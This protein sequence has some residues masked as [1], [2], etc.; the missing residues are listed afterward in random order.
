MKFGYI[1]LGKKGKLKL[2]S[3]KKKVL[4]LETLK[5]LWQLENVD[6]NYAIIGGLSNSIVSPFSKKLF[7]TS[8]LKGI[9]L[10]KGKIFCYSGTTLSEF[11]NFQ[12]K[13]NLSC[14][15]FLTGIPQ[16][17]IGGLIAQNAG[18]F[19]M[20]VFHGST[21]LGCCWAQMMIMFAVGVMNITGMILITLFILLEKG[22]PEKN[23]LIGKAAGILL[24]LWGAGLFFCTPFDN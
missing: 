23:D 1:D 12:I 19:N 11:L 16:A 18:A 13:N 22:L 2:S 20:G 17:Q 5:D 8:N 15:E 24:C 4:F 3:G 6:S 14:L 9:Y 7:I 21:C 10:H